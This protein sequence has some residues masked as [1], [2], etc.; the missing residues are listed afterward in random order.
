MHLELCLGESGRRLTKDTV[1]AE[2]LK[3]EYQEYIKNGSVTERSL[4]EG[5]D[6]RE[7]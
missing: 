2:V 3:I 6:W 4:T 7:G 1:C 5:R